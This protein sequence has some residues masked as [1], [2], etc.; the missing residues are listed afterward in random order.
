MHYHWHDNSIINVFCLLIIALIWSLDLLHS[1][2]MY[3]FV[4]FNFYQL[5]HLLMICLLSMGFPSN[6]LILKT[7]LI[8][9]L[10]KMVKSFSSLLIER[11][12]SA[13]H[14]CG[15]KLNSVLEYLSKCKQQFTMKSFLI[16]ILFVGTAAAKNSTTYYGK[17]G[18]AGDKELF[19]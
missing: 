8:I 13:N 10:C 1:Y 12:K 9:L 15:S 14:F 7:Y 2:L 4:Y 3:I 17:C 19:K 6:N 18:D 11:I 5:P 16:I